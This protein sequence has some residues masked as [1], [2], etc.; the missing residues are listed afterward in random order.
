[1]KS[2]KYWF[3]LAFL[4]ALG[5]GFTGCGTSSGGGSDGGSGGGSNKTSLS[6]NDTK[7]Q[8]TIR[9]EANNL[10]DY[11]HVRQSIVDA[12]GTA[13][14]YQGAN[15]TGVIETVCNRSAISGSYIEYSCN[16]HEETSSPAGD[17]ADEKRTLVLYNNDTYTVYMD[18]YSL[19]DTKTTKID[20]IAQP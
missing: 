1:M 4:A 17:I 20:T 18:E 9:T 14:F 6:W 16:I 7:T 12:S 11:I 5:L 19:Y 13:I 10:T 3:G 2:K 8:F 15:Y